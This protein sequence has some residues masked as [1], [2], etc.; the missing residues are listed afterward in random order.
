MPVWTVFLDSL[1][2]GSSDLSRKFLINVSFSFTK[3]VKAYI[4]IVYW[5]SML[6]LSPDHN[7]EIIL[8]GSFDVRIKPAISPW[9]AIPRRQLCAFQRSDSYSSAPSTRCWKKS[10]CE[11]EPARSSSNRLYV[12]PPLRLQA[13]RDR[14]RVVPRSDSACVFTKRLFA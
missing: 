13:L 2:P 14:S 9:G 8:W 7:L 10:V 12:M 11:Y 5:S 6:P 4:I 1:S 3:Q